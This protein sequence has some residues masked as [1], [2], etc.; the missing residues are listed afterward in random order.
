MQAHFKSGQKN[1]NTHR[2]S[3]TNQM[4]SLCR[5]LRSIR[6][7]AS[8][9]PV[10]KHLFPSYYVERSEHWSEIRFNREWSITN[11]QS[12]KLRKP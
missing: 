4:L 12:P 8:A 5:I 1:S 10:V 6:R 9:I 3:Q 11:D 7:R 2:N